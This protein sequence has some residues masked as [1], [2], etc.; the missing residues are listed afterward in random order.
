MEARDRSFLQDQW[1]KS[2]GLSTA[3]EWRIYLYHKPKDCTKNNINQESLIQISKSH[4]KKLISVFFFLIYLIILKRIPDYV[5]SLLSILE[6]PESKEAMWLIPV[7]Q[8]KITF[9]TV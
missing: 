4:C 9:L 2:K 1:I 5:W 3:W 8:M 7:S 6:P